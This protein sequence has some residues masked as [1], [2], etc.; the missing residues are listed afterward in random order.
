MVHDVIRKC[1]GIDI[2][3]DNPNE[4]IIPRQCHQNW[5]AD[6]EKYISQQCMKLLSTQLTKRQ[7]DSSRPFGIM[8]DKF[9]RQ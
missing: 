4:Q 8:V 2:H 1:S 3:A 5:H 7:I 9:W 6:F